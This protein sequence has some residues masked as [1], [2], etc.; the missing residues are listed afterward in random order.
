MKILQANQR[1][2]R[3]LPKICDVK[4]HDPDPRLDFFRLNDAKL[5]EYLTDKM[6]KAEAL[7]AEKEKYFAF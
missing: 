7:F 6:N 4:S 1:I 5:T 3:N 2:L